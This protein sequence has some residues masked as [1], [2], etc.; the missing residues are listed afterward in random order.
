MTEHVN[1]LELLSFVERVETV[2]AEVDARRPDRKAIFDEAK[3]K[4]V[5]TK[6]MRRLIAERKKARK[7]NAAEDAALDEYRDA[8]VTAKSLVKSGLSLRAAAKQAGV[9]KSS[10]HRALAVPEASQPS[11][12]PETGEITETA[13][14]DTPPGDSGTRAESRAA[15]GA[16]VANESNAAPEDRIAD[17][18]SSLL[19]GPSASHLSAPQ[20]APEGG[21]G[22]GTNPEDWDDIAETQ[23]KLNEAIALRRTQEPADAQGI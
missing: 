15:S 18:P 1:P 21:V 9:S 2:D 10:V 14:L 6:V 19:G 7:A 12:D 13:E 22:A 4:G 17:A 5:N 11:H 23:R 20:P 8:L 3:D 16:A